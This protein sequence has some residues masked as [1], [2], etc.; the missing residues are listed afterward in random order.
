MAAFT[1]YLGNRNYSSWSLR[2]W[3]ACKLAGI[4]FDEKLV[5]FDPLLESAEVKARLRAASPSGRVP[6]LQHGDLVVWDSLAIGE[7][8]AD[9]FPE[10]AMWPRDR[11]ARAIARA[12]VS[13]MHAGFGALRS[14]HPMNI[15][16]DKPGALDAAARADVARIQELWRELRG[17]FGG[18]GRYLFGAAPCLADAAFAPV[19]V[20]LTGYRTMIA[21][22]AA[23]YCRAI[24]DW[25]A[26][27][28]WKTAA[29]AEPWIVQDDE[30]P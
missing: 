10:R 14:Q 6:V 20:R 12:A 30:V 1:L 5:R 18:G 25:P 15:R 17:R 11:A 28:E 27:Q 23:D 29:L 22:D 16:R 19:A 13:E 21:E 7:Y 3:L 4:A 9:L 2:G 8:L 24:W 26:M